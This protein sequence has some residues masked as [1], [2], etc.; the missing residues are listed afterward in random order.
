MIYDLRIS[1]INAGINFIAINIMWHVFG[2]S[3]SLQGT[4]G[5]HRMMKDSLQVPA[6]GLIVIVCRRGGSRCRG[7]QATGRL[8]EYI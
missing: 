2:T 4:A 8:N 1:D 7:F 5:C 6:S 3:E